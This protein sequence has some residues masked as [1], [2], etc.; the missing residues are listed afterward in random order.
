MKND[1]DVKLF[2]NNFIDITLKA[3]QSVQK[4]KKY[5]MLFQMT[6]SSWKSRISFIAFYYLDFQICTCEFEIYE[7]FNSIY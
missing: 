4:I 6:I 1:K 5:H 2:N 7:V 3:S